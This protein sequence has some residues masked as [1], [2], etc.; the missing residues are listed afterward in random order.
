VDGD[1]V[2]WGN[3]FE[4]RLDSDASGAV[5]SVV[6]DLS[7]TDV[8]LVFNPALTRF[9]LGA[10]NGVTMSDIT[11]SVSSDQKQATLDFAPG[12]FAPGDHFHFGTSVFNPLQGSSHLDADRMRGAVV[13]VTMEDGTRHQGTVTAQRTRGV[14]RWTGAGLVD[15][16]AAIRSIV[17]D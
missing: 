12:S 11:Y 2:R 15:A 8:P 14:N 6:L 5:A 17:K 13:T 9:Y 3:Y 7:G 10:S 16:A 1:W 4:L